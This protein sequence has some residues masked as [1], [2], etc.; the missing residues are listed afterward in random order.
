MKPDKRNR[1]RA[2]EAIRHTAYRL[3]ITGWLKIT[4]KF[5][6]SHSEDRVVC[7]TTADWEYRQASFLWNLQEVAS[8]ADDELVEVAIHE[9]CHALNHPMASCFTDTQRKQYAK[10]EELATENVARAI[11]H[12]LQEK[13]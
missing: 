5:D 12:L 3:G 13:S 4:V 11:L 9:L 10:L 2:E 7:Q 6:E 1:V 8:M